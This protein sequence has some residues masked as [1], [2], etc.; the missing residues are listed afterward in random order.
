MSKE[1]MIG[2]L[3]DKPLEKVV[4]DSVGYLVDRDGKRVYKDDKGLTRVTDKEVIKAILEA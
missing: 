4:F 2:T 1:Y 3:E